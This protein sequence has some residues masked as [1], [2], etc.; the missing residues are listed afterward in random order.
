MPSAAATMAI[1][2]LNSDVHLI[3]KASS[4]FSAPGL[5][6]RDSKVAM[7]D[8]IDC[9]D[10]FVTCQTRWGDRVRGDPHPSRAC[11]G[12]LTAGA[13]EAERE[14]RIGH[15]NDLRLLHHGLVDTRDGLSPE[16]LLSAVLLANG[17]AGKMDRHRDDF[18]FHGYISAERSSNVAIRIEGGSS[19]GVSILSPSNFAHAR[20]IETGHGI[21]AKLVSCG[22]KNAEPP[23][24]SPSETRSGTTAN[25]V[26]GISSRLF[27][28]P[29][30]ADFGGVVVEHGLDF[31]IPRITLS[32]LNAK[33][34]VVWDSSNLGHRTQT[35]SVILKAFS[36]ASE[37][38]VI[39]HGS[40]L[41]IYAY[42]SQGIHAFSYW[43]G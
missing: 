35:S 27:R 34:C 36:D 33:N 39:H 3:E 10:G 25:A 5:C 28:R 11:H 24:G 41:G 21:G 31:A 13:M 22:S 30:S 19:P 23:V 18:R 2:D 8:G 17:A 40:I 12:R 29:A 38:V 37:N 7:S 9:D 6:R 43:L 15:V 32:V 4:S 42:R 1:N 26:E 14:E 16:C 20:G